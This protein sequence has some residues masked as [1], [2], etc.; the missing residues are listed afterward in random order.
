MLARVGPAEPRQP[1]G[2]QAITAF[3]VEKQPVKDGEQPGAQRL[4]LALLATAAQSALDRGLHQVVGAAR[5]TGQPHGKAAQAG[6]QLAPLVFV[7]IVHAKGPERWG[8]QCMGQTPGTKIY[9]RRGN[10]FFPAPSYR[11][12]P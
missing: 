9:S 11:Q 7:Q 2:M 1:A 4:R 8:Y 5:I 3:A 12:L 6:Q 10:K